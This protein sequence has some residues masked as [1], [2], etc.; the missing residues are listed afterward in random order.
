MSLFILG[1][2]EKLEFPS[3]DK[4]RENQKVQHTL[5]Y[6]S[7]LYFRSDTVIWRKGN[8]SRYPLSK[9]IIKTF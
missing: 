8:F 5:G 1:H 9:P 3:K 6:T 2:L 4:E 7:I